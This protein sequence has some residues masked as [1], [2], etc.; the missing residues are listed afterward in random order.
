MKGPSYAS[1]QSSSGNTDDALTRQVAGFSGNTVLFLSDWS[2]SPNKRSALSQ[3]PIALSMRHN[4]GSAPASAFDKETGE[5]ATP[6]GTKYDVRLR[7]LSREPLSKGCPLNS[8]LSAHDKDRN[9][10]PPHESW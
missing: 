4:H 1:I 8:H 10:A 6:A 7:N 9:S 5:M 3:A 2:P